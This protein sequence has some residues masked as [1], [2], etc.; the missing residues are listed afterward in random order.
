MHGKKR[1][2]ASKR[3]VRKKRGDAAAAE[4][5]LV[6]GRVELTLE[7]VNQVM[8]RCASTNHGCRNPKRS[9]LPFCWA[10][11]DVAR[12]AAAPFVGAAFRRKY[13]RTS[14]SD[15]GQERTVC[16]II[17]VRLRRTA[18]ACDDDDDR[19]LRCA[20]ASCE[21][22]IC[23]PARVT[24]GGFCPRPPTKLPRPTSRHV[25][26]DAVP[27]VALLGNAGARGGRALV[28]MLGVGAARALAALVLFAGAIGD[29][30]AAALAARRSPLSALG[31]SVLLPPPL[32]PTHN[33][34]YAWWAT[35]SRGRLTLT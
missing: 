1:R 12:S 32:P 10:A 11:S 24:G 15:S 30:A 9:H 14:R 22:V 27:L 20:R 26:A 34:D 19:L 33:Y 3:T 35:T 13:L 16:V 31:L 28:A 18:A 5:D 25:P 4:M 17:Q 7:E 23:P 6:G 21:D 2:F 29:A 8:R